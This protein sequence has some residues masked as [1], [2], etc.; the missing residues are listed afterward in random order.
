MHCP[1][2]SQAQEF[3]SLLMEDDRFE[4]FRPATMGLVCFR[5]K[6]SNK[7]HCMTT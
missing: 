3:E 7:V 1:Q 5:L 2:V 6:G 4:L